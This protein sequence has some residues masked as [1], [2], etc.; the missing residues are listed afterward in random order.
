MNFFDNE[1]E[2]IDWFQTTVDHSEV[3][4]PL[5]TDDAIRVFEAVHNQEKWTKWE[6][7]S[8]KDAPP[9][10]FYSNEYGLMMDVMR[11]DDHSRMSATNKLINPTNKR[12]SELQ[13]ELKQ[14]GLL[15]GLPNVTKTFINATTD[16]PTAEDHNYQFYYTGFERIVKK[17]I[18]SIPLYRKNHPNHLVVFFVF[19]ESSAYVQVDDKKIIERGIKAG[20]AFDCAVYCQFLD[21]KMVDVFKGTDIDYLI[22]YTPFKHYE[23]TC[24]FELPKVCVYDVKKYTYEDVI[25]Y[26]EEFIMS[27]EE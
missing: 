27:T 23:S 20:E 13:K 14:S 3:F 26:P 1:E 9:P 5:C 16:L 12:E 25:D 17:H 10:D 19:D 8:G 18:K 22:W 7:S 4:F 6:N 2:I 15:K 11:V 21:K 24:P